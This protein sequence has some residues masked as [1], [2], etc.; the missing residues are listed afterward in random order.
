MTAL[1]HMSTAARAQA[2][3]KHFTWELFDHPPYSADLTSSDYHLFTYLKNWVGS[4][5]L[6]NNELMEGVKTWLGS[7][8][9]DFFD[10]DIQKFIP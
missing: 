5:H 2:L 6:K 9:A 7:H 10:T 8:V 3:L 1:L 4:Q